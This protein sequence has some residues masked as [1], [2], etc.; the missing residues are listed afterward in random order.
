MLVL[1]L[2]FINSL[3]HSADGWTGVVPWGLALS[4][5]TVLVLIVTNWFGR[6][7]VYRYGTGVRSHE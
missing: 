6:T 7:M 2:A 4:A 1:I 5:L 3:V